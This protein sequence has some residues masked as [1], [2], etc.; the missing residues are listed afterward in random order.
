MIELPMTGFAGRTEL[1]K[2]LVDL[3]GEASNEKPI[4]INVYGE[5]GVGKST[6]ISAVLQEFHKKIFTVDVDLAKR[7][8][9][10]PE[11]ALYAIR[12]EIQA[13]FADSFALFD[14]LYLMRV[15]R[16]EGKF[17][18][19]PAEFFNHNSSV[20][21]DV[22]SRYQSDTFFSRLF[23]KAVEEG[24]LDE[25]FENHARKAVLRMFQSQNQLN[26]E[27]LI[28]AFAQ[29]MREFKKTQ[30]Q[31]MVIV[32]ENADELFEVDDCGNSWVVS[33]VDKAQC[34]KFIFI[35]TNPLTAQK[36]GAQTLSVKLENFDEMEAFSYFESMGISREAI[37]D[38]VFDNCIGNPAMIS[39]SIETSDLIEQQEGYEPTPD[40]YEADPESIVHLHMSTLKSDFAKFAKILSGLRVFNSELFEVL[41]SEYVPET[42][43]RTLPIKVFTDLRFCERVPGGFY[44]ISRAYRSEARKALDSETAENVHYL[45]YQYYVSKLKSGEDYLNRP[46][47]I[48]EAVHHAKENLDIDGF[49]MWFRGLEKNFLS[50]EFFNMW[51]G[52]YEIVRSHTAEILGQTH[53]STVAL[54]DTLSFLYL[55]SGRIINADEIM[56]MSLEAHVEEFGKNTKETVIPI[57]KLASLYMQTGDQ[58]A[59]EKLILNGMQIRKDALGEEHPDVADSMMKLSE[60]YRMMKRIKEAVEL[61]ER[62]TAILSKGADQEDE[63]RLESEERMA[64]MYAKTKNMAKAVHIY[65]KL[66]A[67]KSEKYGE[68]SKEAIDSLG[69]YAESVLKNG[70]PQ[71]AVV[72]YEDLYKKTLKS[73]GD[74]SKAAATACNDLAFAY[75][76]NK[77]YEKAEAMHEKALVMKDMLYGDNHPSTATSRSNYA[78]LKFLTGN[79]ADA[80]VNYKKAAKVYETVL[81]KVHQKTALGFNNLGFLTSRMGHFDEAEKYYMEALESKKALGEEGTASFASTLNNIG[82]LMFRTGRKEEAKDY[83]QQA[84]DIYKDV[85]GENH[86][87]TQV[88][89]KNLASLS[90]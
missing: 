24:V 16:I 71:K 58:E 39:Y 33:L 49:L 3:I 26:W 31:D 53:E 64:E 51:L 86:K 56:Q 7:H 13:G 42:D 60:L 55:R 79:Y 12:Q 67:V 36:T 23:Y 46:H 90:K 52:I 21:N 38:T 37:I 76:K 14:L 81:G 2:Q 82:E 1:K 78:Q 18:V 34:G 8:L 4:I 75:Q 59:A 66:S 25:W 83:L 35:S 5:E 48:Y 28:G 27:S 72:L 54:T 62:A 22:F 50:A 6:L 73:Y 61:V 17:E 10:F 65:K 85:L 57:N 15:E 84:Y 19:P 44:T 11:N 70:Q 77:D 47:H 69:S 80:E 30:G 29:G 40:I 89:S 32:I 74:N 63:K 20:L 9:R 87:T 45:A 88:V 68:Y 43:K 41:R